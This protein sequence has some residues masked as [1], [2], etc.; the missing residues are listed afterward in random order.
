MIKSNGSGLLL[1]IAWQV[2]FESAPD[3]ATQSAAPQI[4]GGCAPVQQ[5]PVAPGD[6]IDLKG[7]DVPAASKHWAHR[8]YR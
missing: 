7:P 1:L 2:F 8:D 6:T 3:V 5:Q 4:A